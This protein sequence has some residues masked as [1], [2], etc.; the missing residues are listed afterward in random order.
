L[1]QRNVITLNKV[2]LTYAVILL[3]WVNYSIVIRVSTRGN[4]NLPDFGAT[5]NVYYF[6]FIILYCIKLHMSSITG[7]VAIQR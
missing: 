1:S 7:T 6:V 2:C 4:K 3:E 5:Y